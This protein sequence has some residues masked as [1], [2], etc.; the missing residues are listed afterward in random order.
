MGNI[1]NTYR[2]FLDDSSPAE[3]APALNMRVDNQ[4]DVYFWITTP[5]QMGNGEYNE[6]KTAS[7]RVCLCGLG[8]GSQ[9]SGLA[10]AIKEAIIGWEVKESI[11]HA[12]KN[13]VFERSSGYAGYRCS[14]CGTWVYE[15]ELRKCE[16][17]KK[18]S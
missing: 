10:E 4:G 17:D 7:K 6:T 3:S 15:D 14:K 13:W 5:I 8:G 16:C 18:R 1:N 9:Y 11:A 12:H 2:A